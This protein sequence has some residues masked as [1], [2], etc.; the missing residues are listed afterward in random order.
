MRAP[1]R[2]LVRLATTHFL[3]P[4]SSCY[5]LAKHQPARAPLTFHL[6][7]M[8]TFTASPPVQLY[9]IATPNG[10]KLGVMLEE[11]GIPYEAHTVG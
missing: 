9:S 1:A 4:S 3:L 11:L 6:C 7:A 2:S 8:A 10:I 5:P